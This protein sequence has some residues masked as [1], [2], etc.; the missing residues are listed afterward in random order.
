MASDDQPSANQAEQTG[1][2]KTPKVEHDPIPAHVEPIEA[3]PKPNKTSEESTEEK[4]KSYEKV[5]A[6]WTVVLGVSTVILAVATILSGVVLYVTDHT[7]KD[8]LIE[9]RKAVAATE[10]AA[11]ATEDSVKIA[12]DTARR[13]LRA[14][15]AITG[16]NIECTNC[17][18]KDK[19]IYPP[20]NGPDASE[21]RVIMRVK[22]F[23][24]TPAYE[25]RTCNG[26]LLTKPEEFP[27][28]DFDYAC[29]VACE[30]CPP[31][32]LGPGAEGLVSLYVPPRDFVQAAIGISRLFFFGTINFID[33]F[34]ER[35]ELPFCWVMDGDGK[36]FIP[37]SY[38]CPE[39]NAAKD[40]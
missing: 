18:I 12:S 35:R 14:Y 38:G 36:R 5:M 1:G 10:K 6:R 2:K 9:T 15:L 11:K 33:T 17:T 29:K 31:T 23:G 28:K 34:R 22:N 3:E 16:E 39:H 24:A 26:T 32:T 21:I 40:D 8:T 7:L 19:T 20:K 4:P 13:Q 30:T 25:M 27:P 37:E